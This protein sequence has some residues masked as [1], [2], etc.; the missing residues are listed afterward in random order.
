MTPRRIRSQNIIY[1]EVTLDRK[2]NFL[3][4]QVNS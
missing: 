3:H 2:Q 1:L 4:T